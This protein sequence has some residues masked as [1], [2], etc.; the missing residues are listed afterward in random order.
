DIVVGTNKASTAISAAKVHDARVLIVGQQGLDSED[1]ERLKPLREEAT[2]QILIL[3]ESAE[4][5]DKMNLPY[6]KVMPTSTTRQKLYRLVRDLGSR[7][8]R[9]RYMVRERP[10]I[11]GMVTVLT[12]REHEISL[13]V[14]EGLSN[15]D[16]AQDLGLAE[17]TV[18]NLVSVVMRKMGCKNRVQVALRLA[19]AKQN[20]PSAT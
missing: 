3:G 4:A 16:I 19:K 13:K 9:H 15:R 8:A 12:P 5:V 17:Q 1:I 14:A 2:F 7:D 6:D 18:K 11:Y 10:P 20:D